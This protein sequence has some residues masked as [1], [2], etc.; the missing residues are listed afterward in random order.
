MP[1]LLC[2]K[3]GIETRLRVSSTERRNEWCTLLNQR[4]GFDSTIQPEDLPVGQRS[5]EEMHR[6]GEILKQLIFLVD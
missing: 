3:D 5:A 6:G 2:K 1:H 4:F